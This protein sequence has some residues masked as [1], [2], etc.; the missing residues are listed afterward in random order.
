MS[1][2]QQEQFNQ[3][4]QQAMQQFLPFGYKCE[5]VFTSEDL[6][7]TVQ[8]RFVDLQ[9]VIPGVQHS[10]SKSDVLIKY[11]E[12]QYSLVSA[13]FLKLATPRYYRE[14]EVESNSELIA[15][16]LEAAYIDTLDWK[17]QGSTVIES[18][19]RSLIENSP[20]S[21]GN[22]KVKLKM[23][24]G[25]FCMY[26]TAI[27]PNSSRERENQM[28]SFSAEYDSMVK[29]EKS[30]EFAKQLGRDVGKHIGL[31]NDL[32]RDYSQ[33]SILHTLGSFYRNQSGFMGEYLITIDHGPIIYLDKDEIEEVVRKYSE[34]KAS[35]II[36]FV[37]RKRYKEQQEYRFIVSIQGHI[38][39]K[40]ELY[41]EISPELR[42]FV[43]PV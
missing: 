5:S 30:S 28:R 23:V 10:Y 1:K 13:D 37:K 12:A 29:I 8:V 42:N 9:N 21:R 7:Y 35:D 34:V 6:S 4:I 43:L 19:K 15:D 14:L 20:Y 36:P 3:A 39:D 41:L 40:Q 27:T 31:H 33:P 32:K 17:R 25:S 24:C 11:S 18:V 38:F 22:V 16:D 2:I 26:C